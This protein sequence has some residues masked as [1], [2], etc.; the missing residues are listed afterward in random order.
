M[1]DAA[2]ITK[3]SRKTK[4]TEMSRMSL[5]PEMTKMTQISTKMAEYAK[6]NAF[7]IYYLEILI[8]DRDARGE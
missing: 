7:I 1:N 4:I 2:E 5:M 3:I 6:L 8:S